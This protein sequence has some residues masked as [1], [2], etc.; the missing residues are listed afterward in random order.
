MKLKFKSILARALFF[1]APVMVLAFIAIANVNWTIAAL[2]D[3]RGGYA[4]RLPL[5]LSITSVPFVGFLLITAGLLAFVGYLRKVIGKVNNFVDVAAAGDFSQ[6]VDATEGDEFGVMERHL[7]T[8]ISNMNEMSLRSSELL[9]VAEYANRSKSDFLS[10]MSHEIR[11]PMNAIIGMTQIARV[12]T[13]P[14]KISDCLM[15]IDNAS[16]HLLALINDILDMSKI[17]ANKFELTSETF[18]LEGSLHKIY[19]MMNVKA[20]EKKQTLTLSIDKNIPEYIISDELRL[21]QIITN[22]VSNAVKFT[23]E[24]GKIEIDVRE[25]ESAGETHTVRVDVKDNGIGLA[26]GQIDKLFKPFEQG[27]GSVSRK[28]GGTGLGLAINKRIVEMMGGEIW[29]ESAPDMGSVFSFTVKVKGGAPDAAAGGRGVR[30]KQATVQAKDVRILVV[31]DSEEANEY[32]SHILNALGFKCELARDGEEA[33]Q[34][35]VAALSEKRPYSVIFMD[36]MMPK[37]NGIEAA[38]KIKGISGENVTIVMVSMYDWQE[39]EHKAREAGIVKCLSKPISPSTVLDSINEVMPNCV[40]KNNDEGV[41]PP[42]IG[43]SGNTIL[44]VEDIEVNRE[45]ISAFLEGTHV[46]IETAVNGVE[47]VEKFTAD[48][49]KYDIILMDIQMPEMDG[50]EATRRIRAMD[51]KKAKTIPI[52]AMTANALSEDVQKCKEAGMN[53][54]MAKPVDPEALLMK[55]NDFFF[56]KSYLDRDIG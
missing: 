15:K 11:S 35:V 16:R 14:A 21:S 37:L 40:I 4:G 26:R 52:V 46:N 17:E 50:F 29:V 6:R 8:M 34:A 49:K 9:N 41:S 48:P 22:L 44:L 53:D 2:A 38:K 20:E 42:S 45:I 19:D 54:H 7:N 47:A 33:V 28:F 39:F 5:F 18:F 56:M 32:T 55:L 24:G 23:D 31:D 10:R 36:Y 30:K 3:G 13:E 25:V 51:I 43:F 1:V 12:S 27:D